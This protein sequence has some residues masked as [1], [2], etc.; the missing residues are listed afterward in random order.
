MYVKLFIVSF[1]FLAGL[2]F[3]MN[4]KRDNLVESFEVT[5]NC[6]NILMEKDGKFLLYNSRKLEVPGVNPVQFNTLEEYTEFVS[7]LRGSGIKCP[8]LYA[9]EINT[10]QGDKSYKI[11]PSGDPD[12]CG[13]PQTQHPTESKLIDAGHDK[14]SMPS[15]DPNN[16]YIG[17]YTPLD[18]MFHEEELNEES[19]NPM[20]NNW[21][22]A[23]YSREMV[24]SGAYTQDEVKI[25]TNKE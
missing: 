8:V 11:C 12:I 1:I 22:G 15:F 5:S 24:E 16:Q 3:T 10:T 7:W 20:D 21:G 25:N 2:Y 13:L 6:P 9:K 23:K 14:G 4:Y 18:K 19:A 17:E